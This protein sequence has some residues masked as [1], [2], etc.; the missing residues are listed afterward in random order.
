MSEPLIADRYAPVE[1]DDKPVVIDTTYTE[2][3][4]LVPNK[5]SQATM[6]PMNIENYVDALFELKPPPPFAHFEPFNGYSTRLRKLFFR[7]ILS[8]FDPDDVVD[9][10]DDL[11][12]KGFEDPKEEAEKLYEMLHSLGNLNQWLEEIILNILSTLKS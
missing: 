4:E 7:Q 5:A 6:M 12:E 11:F 2:N 8:S 1:W 3:V 10:L 9:R